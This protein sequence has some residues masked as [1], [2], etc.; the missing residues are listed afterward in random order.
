MSTR[1]SITTSRDDQL[2]AAAYLSDTLRRLKFPHAFI[3]GFAWA[4][5]GSSRPTE[6]IDVLIEIKE[7]E[8]IS[9]L[10]EKLEKFGKNF[11]SAGLKFYYVKACQS[12]YLLGTSVGTNKTK[13]GA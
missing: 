4:L 3:G 7:L 11:A 12:I 8:K 1:I 2:A 10:R 9:D 5:L 6:D 13:P